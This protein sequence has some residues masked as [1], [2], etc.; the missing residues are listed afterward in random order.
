MCNGRSS[1]IAQFIN[2]GLLNELYLHMIPTLLGEGIKLFDKIDKGKVDFKK[3]KVLDGE[4]ATHILLQS[5]SEN[6]K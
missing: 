3:I 5:K 4:I 2:Y 6:K 1:T